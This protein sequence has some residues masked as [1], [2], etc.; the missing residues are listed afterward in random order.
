M[1]ISL[2]VSWSFNSLSCNN[3]PIRMKEDIICD[4]GSKLKVLREVERIILIFGIHN[5]KEGIVIRKT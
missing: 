1:D 3:D 4:I 2:I 5:L